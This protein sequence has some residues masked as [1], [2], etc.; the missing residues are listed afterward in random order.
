M[1]SVKLNIFSIYKVIGTPGTSGASIQT[2]AGSVNARFGENNRV[3]L[4]ADSVPFHADSF[5]NKA[6]KPGFG[7]LMLYGIRDT[8]EEMHFWRTKARE[9]GA[10]FTSAE[11]EFA[12]GDI[13]V[14]LTDRAKLKAA[15]G[16]GKFLNLRRMTS[17]LQSQVLHRFS[18]YAASE[19]ANINEEM[20]RVSQIATRPDLFD[21]LLEDD[22]DL[23]KLDILV[24][25][26]ADDPAAPGRMRQMA[27]VKPGAEILSIVQGSD[28][29]TILLPIW[30]TDGVVAKRMR[31]ETLAAA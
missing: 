21:K 19:G 12:V 15:S 27:Y 9:M 10:E 1:S 23:A 26:V 6:P 29:A 20:T 16:K 5:R 13:E 8:L 25:P 30:M 11:I 17:A 28:Q 7:L 3:E 18:E 24:V 31:R 14:G 4:L 2:L 22:S